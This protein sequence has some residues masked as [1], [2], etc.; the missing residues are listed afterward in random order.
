MAISVASI[1]AEQA[2]KVLSL[3]EGHFA[4]VKAIEIAPSK[5]TQ[6]LSA[7]A[8]ADGGELY[9]G[10]AEQGTGKPRAWRRRD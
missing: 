7:F 3:E 10:I 2:A 1:S 6:T 9:I 5:L 8:N 4:G